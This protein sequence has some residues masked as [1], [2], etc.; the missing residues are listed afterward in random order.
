MSF[1]WVTLYGGPCSTLG[2]SLSLQA[3]GMYSKVPCSRH[4]GD[5]VHKLRP[6]W[7]ATS[8]KST[9][10]GAIWLPKNISTAL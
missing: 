9:L 8:I 4:P 3:A 6:L 5:E 1:L 10:S 2:F 7:A